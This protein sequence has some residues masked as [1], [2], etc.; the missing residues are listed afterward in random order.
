MTVLETP[1]V[2]ITT[3]LS[4]LSSSRLPGKEHVTSMTTFK[5]GLTT[6]QL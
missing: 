3:T 4:R 5:V 6:I 1:M 2:T